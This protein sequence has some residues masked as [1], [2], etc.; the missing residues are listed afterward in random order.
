MKR[1]IFSFFPYHTSGKTFSWWD[2]FPKKITECL[3]EKGIYHRVYYRDYA[4]DSQYPR[5]KH[6]KATRKQIE[7]PFWTWRN[8]YKDVNRFD[9]VIIHSHIEARPI[10]NGLCIFNNMF[11]KKTKWIMTDHD[12]WAPVKFSKSKMKIRSLFR[13]IGFLPEVVPGCSRASKKRLQ[14][15]YGENNVGYI[16]NG[17]DIPDIAEPKKL[18][19][20]PTRALFVG[21]LESYK[22][23][24]VIIEAFKKI[25]DNSTI[26]TIVGAGSIQSE[27]GNY[28]SNNG[29][30]EKI[31]LL[32][33]RKDIYNIMLEHD[34]A[35]IPT[36]YEENFPIVSLEAQSC[37]LPCIYTNSGGLVETQINGK[38]GVMI[39]KNNPDEILRAV[40]YFQDDIERFNRMCINARQNAL[41]FTIEKMAK[42][43]C[44]LYMRIFEDGNIASI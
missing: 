17:I 2:K 23:L 29:L 39:S 42:N 10:L 14:N 1:A 11:N 25:K 27:L 33:S 41:N 7:N 38:T 5:D 21:R 24:W 36:I 28:V 40:E 37:Y 13:R 18:S 26:L 8:L 35:I 34:F 3:D 6:Y 9:R 4:N 12:L 16:Y 44:D 20:K 22:G 30:G 31:R 32:G 43:Y 19:T 15:I